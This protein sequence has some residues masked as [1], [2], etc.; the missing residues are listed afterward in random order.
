MQSLC[1]KKHELLK[2]QSKNADKN[3]TIPNI[4]ANITNVIL[5]KIIATNNVIEK[6]IAPTNSGQRTNLLISIDNTIVTSI[7]AKKI[8][9]FI[10]F[11]PFN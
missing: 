7:M 6:N 3:P 9:I 2:T 1:L 11:H 4:I 10:I 8:S 5:D